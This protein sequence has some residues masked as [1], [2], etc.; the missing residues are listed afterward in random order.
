MTAVPVP[1]RRPSGR[2]P[3]PIEAGL[4]V[5]SFTP[6]LLVVATLIACGAAERLPLPSSYEAHDPAVGSQ[7]AGLE[8]KVRSLE[9]AAATGPELAAA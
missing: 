4:A 5:R 6:R 1:L 8:R 2:H 9:D 3:F 7:I